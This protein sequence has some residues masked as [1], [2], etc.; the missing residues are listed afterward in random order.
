MVKPEQ[1]QKSGGKIVA[2]SFQFFL[3]FQ[4]IAEFMK[5]ME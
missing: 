1:A 2:V 4:T 3:L 5:C